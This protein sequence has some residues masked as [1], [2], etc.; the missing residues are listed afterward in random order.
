MYGYVCAYAVKAAVVAAA[1]ISKPAVQSHHMIM[2]AV[3]SSLCCWTCHVASH[4]ASDLLAPL[5]IFFCA[6]SK[7]ERRLPKDYQ[8]G[9]SKDG[10]VL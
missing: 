10:L 1:Q 2:H 5:C 6:I 8:P 3:R 9:L 7:A 4:A